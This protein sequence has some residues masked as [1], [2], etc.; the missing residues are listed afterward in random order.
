MIKAMSRLR[1]VRVDRWS[2]PLTLVV[3]LALTVVPAASSAST[4]TKPSARVTP[5]LLAR[6][7]TSN[8]VYIFAT[9]GCGEARCVRLYRSNSDATQFKRV[10]PPPVK[11]ERGGIAESTLEKLVFANPDDGF[12]FVAYGNFG[13]TMYATSNGARTWREVERVKKGQLDMYVSSSRIF[14]TS[15]HCVPKT[16][17]C[18]QFTTRRS[19][20]AA[21][22]WAAVPRLWTTGTG[23]NDVYYGPAIASYGNVVWEL[24]SGPDYWWTSDN[25]GQTFTRTRLRFPQL[26]SVSGCSFYPKTALVLWAECPT[27]MQVSFWHSSDG[28]A[29]WSPVSQSQFFGTGGGAFAAVTQAVAYLDYGGVQGKGNFVRLSDGGRTATVVGELHCTDVT[30]LFTSTRHGLAVC[31]DNYTNYSLRETNDGGATW[32]TVA[33]PRA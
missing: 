31:N 2:V 27:G 12:A 29:L 23:S 17:N 14:L 33:L 7:G 8:V 21:R 18:T 11:G 20:L 16:M 3:A 22:T 10:E 13:V 26:V 32:V 15:V 30:L 19:N 1:N 24:E 9:T 6:A 28:G 4:G 5:A 25:D